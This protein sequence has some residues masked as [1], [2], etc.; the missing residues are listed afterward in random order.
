MRQSKQSD[1]PSG[2]CKD[3]YR[4]RVKPVIEHEQAIRARERRR[5]LALVDKPLESLVEDPEFP[6]CVW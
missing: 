1:S 2:Y 4:K 5:V 3:V 6:G